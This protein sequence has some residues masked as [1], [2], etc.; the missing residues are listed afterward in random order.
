MNQIDTLIT[1]LHYDTNRRIVLINADDFRRPG[2]LAYLNISN[3]IVVIVGEL[4]RLHRWKGVQYPNAEIFRFFVGGGEITA[5]RALA[6]QGV[7][8]GEEIPKLKKLPWLVLSG[9]SDSILASL[10][11]SGI[12]KCQ[13]C[14]LQKLDKQHQQIHPY[15]DVVNEQN[16]TNT[17]SN[18]PTT[19]PLMPSIRTLGGSDGTKHKSYS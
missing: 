8:L 1:H 12:H 5:A 17:T 10:R 15:H 2:D 16:T 4:R 6:A 9:E 18:N 11:A 14:T 13:A 7:A 3:D 19:T